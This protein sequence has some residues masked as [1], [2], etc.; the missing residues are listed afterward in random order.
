MNVS[1]L[2]FV[3]SAALFAG[4]EEK[5]AVGKEQKKLQGK[6]V[7]TALRHGDAETPRE[8]LDRGAVTLVI[9]GNRFIFTTPKETQKGTLRVDGS[10]SPRTLDLV[11]PTR[12]GEKKTILCIYEWDGEV[13]RIA[14][15]QQK[16]PRDFRSRLGGSIVASFKRAGD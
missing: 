16:R 13:L 14:G 15:D 8:E 9:R 11:L 5:G 12:E 3:L 6:W 1:T 2:G 10:K 4:A 7:A